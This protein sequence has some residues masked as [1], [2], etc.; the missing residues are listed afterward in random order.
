MLLFLRIKIAC[1]VVIHARG[2]STTDPDLDLES[3]Q[4]IPPSRPVSQMGTIFITLKKNHMY[5]T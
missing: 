5:S 1:N 3:F 2:D 4:R